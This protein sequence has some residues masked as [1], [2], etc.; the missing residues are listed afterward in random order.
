[1]R[2]FSGTEYRSGRGIAVP[3]LNAPRTNQG[4]PMQPVPMTGQTGQPQTP[5]WSIADKMMSATAGD[6]LTKYDWSEDMSEDDVDYQDV[7]DEWNSPRYDVERSYQVESTLR[8]CVRELIREFMALS[9]GG[10]SGVS[11]GQVSGVV[12][13]LGT[14]PKHPRPEDRRGSKKRNRKRL[15]RSAKQFGGGGFM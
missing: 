1:M 8:G 7:W 12:T 15:R 11:S 5:K 13:P 10:A 6:E 2:F 14:G 4:I 3:S 9:T